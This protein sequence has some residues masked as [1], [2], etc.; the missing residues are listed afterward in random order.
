MS[1]VKVWYLCDG[2][3][4]AHCNPE[5]KHTSKVEHAKNF[6]ASIDGQCGFVE[7]E[8]RN[9]APDKRDKGGGQ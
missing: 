2:T 9:D 7:Q 3:A 6:K 5:C 4:C 8:S 1:D